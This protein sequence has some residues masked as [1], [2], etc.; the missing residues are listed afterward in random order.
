I[1]QM[2]SLA[3]AF[4]ITNNGTNVAG[5]IQLAEQATNIA[6]G[7]TLRFN[8]QQALSGSCTLTLSGGALVD[9]AN[10]TN[11]S[12]V[13]NFTFNPVTGALLFAADQSSTAAP[14][15]ARS[16]VGSSLLFHGQLFDYDAG[17]C[18]MRARFYDPYSGLF[19][20]PDPDG[21][22]DSP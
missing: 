6:F 2:M 11:T 17:L 12:Q 7:V 8:P 3:N 1:S 15:L 10:N 16:A 5:S 21:Y 20:Q 9:E 19:L 18:Y 22:E 4:T 14:V 13:V